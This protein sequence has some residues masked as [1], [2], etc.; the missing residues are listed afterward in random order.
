MTPQDASTLGFGVVCDRTGVIDRFIR[1]DL[2]VASRGPRLFSELLDPES[3]SKAQQ[4]LE[5]IVREGAAFNWEMNVRIGQT[6]ETLFFAGGA[7]NEHVLICG[8]RSSGH[9]GDFYD[10]L[11]RISNEQ[12]NLTRTALKEQ[13]RAAGIPQPANVYDEL[14]RLNNEMATLQRELAKRNV[15]LE[16]LNEEKNRAIGIVA[17]DLRNPLQTILL[18]AEVLLL[19]YEPNL[20]ETQREVIAAIQDSSR[21]MLKLVN[22]V[23]DIAAIEAGKLRL[24]LE[25][26]D[27]AALVGDVAHQ[28]RLIA[29]AEQV[30]VACDAA[31]L[32]GVTIQGDAAKLRQVL[33]NLIHNAIK[34]SP[35]GETVRVIG[36]R[37]DSDAVILICDRGPGISAAEVERLFRPFE[38][39][40]KTGAGRS[41]AGL[42]L[43]IANR[44]V[45]GHGGAIEVQS[46]I[47]HGAVFLVRLPWTRSG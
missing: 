27:L 47:G 9:V 34:F 6:P 15:E 12:A 32:E 17:H 36:E 3:W 19:S 26:I 7:V 37:R 11:V 45:A 23:L 2:G 8:V 43:A 21:Y 20:D 4:F 22:D 38:S 10:E 33:N 39:G 41:G 40:R 1:D 5:T 42:G 18:S 25:E 46:E 44:I 29:R 31:A 24:D 28:N 35:P 16:R 13:A 14:T 30:E